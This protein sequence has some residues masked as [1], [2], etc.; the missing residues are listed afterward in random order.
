[1]GGKRGQL[2]SFIDKSE[3]IQQDS[4][5]NKPLHRKH[6]Y[7]Y[8][9]LPLSDAADSIVRQ[10]SVLDSRPRSHHLFFA[11]VQSDSAIA[12]L[13]LRERP[14]EYYKR[15]YREKTCWY[16]SQ[17]VRPDLIILATREACRMGDE[18]INPE[19]L[20]APLGDLYAFPYMQINLRQLVAECR[21]RPAY[22]LM[23]EPV[24]ARTRWSLERLVEFLGLTSSMPSAV[25]PVVEEKLQELLEVLR[26]S[27]HFPTSL[28]DE[29]IRVVRRAEKQTGHSSGVLSM[30]WTV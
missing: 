22:P 25:A 29:I 2:V 30:L 15:V 7:S 26:L 21:A 23:T 8:Q 9:T 4:H 1:M 6:M 27:Y 14:L 19:H 10:A 5:R 12:Q 18:V 24:V 13:L 16:P 3:F 17:I 28:R 20:L 11:I